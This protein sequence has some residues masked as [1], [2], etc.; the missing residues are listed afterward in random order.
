MTRPS[1]WRL[2]IGIISHV[3]QQSGGKRPPH[4]QPD[5]DEEEDSD[6]EDVHMSEPRTQPVAVVDD[7]TAHERDVE[8]AKA[9]AAERRKN[10][11][12]LYKER[13][14]KRQDRK[15][16]RMSFFFKDP[17]NAIKIFFSAHYRDKGYT[18][19]VLDSA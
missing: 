17:E 1:Q 14:E 13:F 2:Y 16:S 3:Q 11:E 9:A 10:N 7:A 15:D 19:S 18:W 4:G 5:P 8:K 12:E 6:D